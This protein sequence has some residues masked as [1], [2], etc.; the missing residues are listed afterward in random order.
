[1]KEK[2][3]NCKNEMGKV[4]YAF[5]KSYSISFTS[6]HLTCPL[7]ALLRIRPSLSAAPYRGGEVCVS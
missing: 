5:P 1:M 2:K 4:N 7:R 3:V 6:P